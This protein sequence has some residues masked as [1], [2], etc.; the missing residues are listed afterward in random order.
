MAPKG[1]IEADAFGLDTWM[2]SVGAF[3]QSSLG[4]AKTFDQTAALEQLQTLQADML[5]FVDARMEKD[6]KAI[7]RLSEAKTPADFGRIQ[8]EYLQDL[9]VDYNRQA[10]KAA[11]EAG[12]AMMAAVHRL[13]KGL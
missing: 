12:K 5:A 2:K 4:E 1:K 7:Q 6:M 9:M 10:V 3:W 8:L 11:E 13:P